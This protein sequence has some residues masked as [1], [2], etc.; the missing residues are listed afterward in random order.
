MKRRYSPLHLLLEAEILN[1]GS[2]PLRKMAVCL[3]NRGMRV[4]GNY[5]ISKKLLLRININ[6]SST[7]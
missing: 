1:T 5:D 4:F 2:S 7:V 3:L 6:R